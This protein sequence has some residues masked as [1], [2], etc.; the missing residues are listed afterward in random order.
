MKKLI[1]ISL[2]LLTCMSFVCKAQSF[3]KFLVAVTKP[4]VNVRQAPN[5]SATVITK[6]PLGTVFEMIS[7]QTGWYEVKEAVTGKKGYISASVSKLCPD[8]DPYYPRTTDDIVDITEFENI[9]K[10]QN[11]E[12]TVTYGFRSKDN[13]KTNIIYASLST[14]TADTSGRMRSYEN[15]YKGKQMGWYIIL[16]EETDYEGTVQN[17]LDKP[18][19]VFRESS[20][21]AGIYIQGVYYKDANNPFE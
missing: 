19:L 18:I 12:T 9:S 1:S 2:I 10:K 11:S 17:K 21:K 4:N 6:A 15:Y 20:G 16:D 7:K 13:K 3:P 8:T 5:S 14:T